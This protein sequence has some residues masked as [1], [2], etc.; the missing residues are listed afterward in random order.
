[1]TVVGDLKNNRTVHSLA[2]ILALYQGVKICYVSPE[3]LR[4]PAEIFKELNEKGIEQHETSGTRKKEGREEDRRRR[5]EKK[6]GEEIEQ[7]KKKGEGIS[8]YPPTHQRALEHCQGTLRGHHSTTLNSQGRVHHHVL[9]EKKRGEARVG[10][11]GEAWLNATT[12]I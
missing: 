2:R 8:Y 11:G 5:Q 4:M 12:Q 9:R 1:V 7:R 10:G 3:T 6:T